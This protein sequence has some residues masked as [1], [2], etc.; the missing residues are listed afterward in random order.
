MPKDGIAYRIA[1]LLEILNIRIA[2]FERSIGASNGVIRKAIA[3]GTDIQSKWAT[4]IVECYPQV[5]PLWLLTGKGEIINSDMPPQ[6]FNIK[7][8]ISQ[9]V[10]GHGGSLNIIKDRPHDTEDISCELL[11]R[12]IMEKDRVITTL[13]ET[14]DMLREQ[15]K[16]KDEQIHTILMAT[17]SHTKA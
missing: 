17:F 10:V 3:N 16:T 14:N 8:D 12:I 11:D 1:Q 13:S 15:I 2:E 7:G 4:A 5:S 9:S 6:S